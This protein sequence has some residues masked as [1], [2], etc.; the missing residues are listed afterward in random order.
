ML[1][2]NIKHYTEPALSSAS[3]MVIDIVL[4]KNFLE[5]VGSRGDNWNNQEKDDWQGRKIVEELLYKTKKK[6]HN[7]F[8]IWKMEIRDKQNHNL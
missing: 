6:D 8:S 3:S 2:I 1:D 5:M 4:H 7:D